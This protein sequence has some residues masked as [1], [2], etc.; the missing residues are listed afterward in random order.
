MPFLS[1]CCTSISK[2]FYQLTWSIA[3]H[4]SDFFDGDIGGGRVV[5]SVGKHW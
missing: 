5:F 3:Y 2:E 4:D 1:M